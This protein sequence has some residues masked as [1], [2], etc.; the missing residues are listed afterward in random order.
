MRHLANLRVAIN[1]QYGISMEN[2]TWTPGYILVGLLGSMKNCTPVEKVDAMRLAMALRNTDTFDLEE[3]DAKVC[4]TAINSAKDLP[5]FAYTALLDVITGKPV[6]QPAPQP[7]DDATPAE[8]VA[9]EQP[10]QPVEAP[11]VNVEVAVEAPAAPVQEPNPQP[12][13][14]TQA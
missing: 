2:E 1:N 11:A 6:V 14:E 12:A 13:Q 3:A 7:V 8:P 4:M 10:A 5:A 9:P